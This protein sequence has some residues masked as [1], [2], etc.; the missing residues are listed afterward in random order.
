MMLDTLDLLD[1]LD[2][3]EVQAAAQAHLLER[4]AL[5][6]AQSLRR[7]HRVQTRRIKND[8]DMA[9]LLPA[10]IAQGD[11]WHVLSTGDLDVLSF[12]RHLLAG[13]DYFASVLVT[14]WRINR[15]DLEQI[16]AWLD[17]GRIETF[18]LIIDQRFGRLA[19]DEYK[20]AQTIAADYGGSV[21]CCLNHSKITLCDAPHADQWLVVE[22]SANVN[23]NHRF[24]Q[25]AVHNSRELHN[26]Y[27]QAFDRVRRRSQPAPR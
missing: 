22:S 14:T 4:T 6:Q 18:H 1:G 13:V 15:D 19:P 17:A 26:F 25:T 7:A 8:A 5:G 21:T 10:T 23:T 27:Q 12:L 2:P 24:E 20:L 11:S 3:A 16:Q 9:R